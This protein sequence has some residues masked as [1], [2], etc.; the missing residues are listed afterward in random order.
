MPYT[1]YTCA[2]LVIADV[3]TFAFILKALLLLFGVTENVY[4]LPPL[5]VVR[6]AAPSDV[7]ALKSVI[8]T[9]DVVYEAVIVHEIAVPALRG[10]V[11]EHDSTEL[12]LAS[13]V[14][15]VSYDLFHLF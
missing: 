9:P 13:S 12:V 3:P 10:A 14:K 5:A 4:V 2:P 15:K 7:I 1:V 6:L 8:P 11:V